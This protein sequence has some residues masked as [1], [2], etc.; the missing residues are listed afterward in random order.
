MSN[1][2]VKG[3]RKPGKRYAKKKGVG[4]K[5]SDSKLNR[6]ARFM[7]KHREEEKRRHFSKHNQVTGLYGMKP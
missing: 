2:M 6:K 3:G 1:R 7:S 4:S 5:P